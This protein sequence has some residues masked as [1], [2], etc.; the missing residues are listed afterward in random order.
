MN[1]KIEK[2]D[3]P[4][5]VE[6]LNPAKTLERI[7]VKSYSDILD[8]GAGSGIFSIAAAHLTKGTVY[9]YDIDEF[10][11]ET[12]NQ[13][14]EEENI[15]SIVLLNSQRL[16]EISDKI[17]VDFVLLSTVYHEIVDKE[18]LFGDIKKVLKKDGRTAVIEFQNIATP[19]GPPVEKRVGLKMLQE[20]FSAHGFK[21][22]DNA[23]LGD[24]FYLAV[25][26]ADN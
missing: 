7:G 12:I 25:F 8:Y 4:R 6:E 2:L 15:S 26:E 1:N 20:D 9:A 23:L 10:S 14:A 3:N 24:N 22:A 17:L 18:A 19:M 11:L 5:R 21:V 16:R 13:K